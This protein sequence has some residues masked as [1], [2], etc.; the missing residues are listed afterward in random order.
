MPG[1]KLNADG[2]VSSNWPYELDENPITIDATPTLTGKDAKN[3]FIERQDYSGAIARANLTAQVKN[4]RGLYGDGVGEDRGTIPR[5]TVTAR[6]LLMAAGWSWMVW[7]RAI[8]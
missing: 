8:R 5:L 6:Q 7:C 1:Q 3:Y 4:W 2:T